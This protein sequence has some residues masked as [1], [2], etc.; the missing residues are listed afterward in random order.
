MSIVRKVYA[1]VLNDR[2]KL[3][4]IEKVMDEH[5]GTMIKSLWSGRL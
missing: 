1:K 3:M 5:W 4:V 2:V